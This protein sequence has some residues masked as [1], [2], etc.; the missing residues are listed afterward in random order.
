MENYYLDKNW[1]RM[2][3][4][5]SKFPLNGKLLFGGKWK[6]CNNSEI[7]NF[8][9][10]EIYY[11]DENGRKWKRYNNWEIANF[12]SMENY[13]LDENEKDPIIQK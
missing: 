2:W 5:N 7:A 4:R 13:Y 12:L 11:L 10:T 9:Q 3:F 1:K 6:I 8:L